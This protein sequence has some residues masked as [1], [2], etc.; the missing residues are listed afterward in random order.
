MNLALSNKIENLFLVNNWTSVL[1]YE[2]DMR[3]AI[4]TN[5]NYSDILIIYGYLFFNV[6]ETFNMKIKLSTIKRTKVYNCHTLCFRE[7]RNT[8]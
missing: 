4:V 1:L 7:G 5:D 6:I 2:K 3:K 8:N